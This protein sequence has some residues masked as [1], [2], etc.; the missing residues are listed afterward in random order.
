MIVK[1]FEDDT[2]KIMDNFKLMDNFEWATINLSTAS[3]NLAPRNDS[4][5]FSWA[6]I[7]LP[8]SAANFVSHN[9]PL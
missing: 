1:R 2:F 4:L 3:A 7:N 9:D 8:S 5:S 6:T